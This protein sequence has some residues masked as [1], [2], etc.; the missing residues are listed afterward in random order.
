[1]LYEEYKADLNIRGE[2]GG[3]AI[4]WAAHYGYDSMVDMLAGRRAHMEIKNDAGKTPVG[5][6]AA[7]GKLQLFNC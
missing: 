6:A 4:W 7:R 2:W 5:I 3:T 1:M